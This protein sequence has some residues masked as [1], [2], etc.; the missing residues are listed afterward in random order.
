MKISNSLLASPMK[1]PAM[2]S[3]IYA[4]IYVL[5]HFSMPVRFLFQE[6]VYMIL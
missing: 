5:A 6:F 4:C 2:N 3:F 1:S